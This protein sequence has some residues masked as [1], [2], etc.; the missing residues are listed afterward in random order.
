PPWPRSPDRGW[1]NTVP[2]GAA[3]GGLGSECVVRWT[4][5]RLTR[6]PASGRTSACFHRSVS[7]VPGA[8]PALVRRQ[9]AARGGCLGVALAVRLTDLVRSASSTA[10]WWRH[11]FA[12]CSGSHDNSVLRP[13]PR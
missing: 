13:A 8:P 2:D 3:S 5:S 7:A 9:V 11:W 10:R 12:G 4:C 1:S 6:G